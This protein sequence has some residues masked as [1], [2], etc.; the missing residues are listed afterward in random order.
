MPTRIATRGS[1]TGFSRMDGSVV[2][3]S[4][5]TDDPRRTHSRT[6][7]LHR[8]AET[9]RL[10]TAR[11][12]TTQCARAAPIP[13]R[14]ESL[15]STSLARINF[16]HDFPIRVTAYSDFTHASGEYQ[17]WEYLRGGLN[18]AGAHRG[19]TTWAPAD[20]T[21]RVPE[22]L[23]SLALALATLT[24]LAVVTP[25]LLHALSRFFSCGCLSPFAQTRPNP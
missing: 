17:K 12:R 6:P 2:G 21:V 5:R 16:T 22:S 10:A 7:P 25:S 23:L 3:F 1:A 20:D 4:P 15:G 9:I 24:V 11:T 19:G 13:V 14:S 18:D 8:S